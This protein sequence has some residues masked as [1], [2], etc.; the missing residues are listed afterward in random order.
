MGGNALLARTYRCPVAVPEGEALLIREWNTRAL[1][2][3][4]A[5]QRAERF[6]V[7]EELVAGK[8]YGWG[9]LSWE[10][11]AAPGL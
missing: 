4:Y 2:L 11:I 7:D 8:R 3:D 9:G 5:D 1:W 6:A 10:A